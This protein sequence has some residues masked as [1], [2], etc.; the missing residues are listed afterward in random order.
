[1]NKALIS[2]LR[3][4]EAVIAGKQRQ[5]QLALTCL[6]AQGHI[7]IEDVPGVG[8]TT[9]AHVLAKV[10]GLDYSRIQFTSDMLPSDI[11]GGSL[12]QG[13]DQLKFIKGPVFTN[14]VLADEIN[15][16]PPRSQSALLE[17]MEEHQVSMEGQT[18]PLPK[19]FFVI[20]TQN[21]REQ[22]GTYPLPESQLDRFHMRIQMG[23][24]DEA[25][26]RQ[27]LAVGKRR[28]SLNDI[29][30]CLSADSVLKLQ[31]EVEQVY[32]SEALL[33]YLQQLLNF[34]RNSQRFEVGLSP[35]AG[36]VLRHCAQAWAYLHD[37][38]HVL[39]E[40]VQTILPYVVEHRLATVA[41]SVS[42]DAKGICAQLSCIAIP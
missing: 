24:P 42:G 11:L 35:R 32:V 18:H 29:E 16:A 19:P 13:H 38:D 27:L 39:P 34:T 10:L 4:S 31:E 23:Y 33:D 12:F 3:Q 15:R 9:L 37:R 17:A 14:I 22:L 7:L 6:L 21:P 25:A 41:D 40:D 2:A 28:K 26:E 36:L 20:A 1:M 30:P 8:K 5:I